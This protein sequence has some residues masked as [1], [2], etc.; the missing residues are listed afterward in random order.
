MSEPR[1]DLC[2]RCAPL[3]TSKTGCNACSS[4]RRRNFLIANQR[5]VQCAQPLEEKSNY[6]CSKCRAKAANTKRDTIRRR[7]KDGFCGEP[8]CPNKSETFRCADCAKKGAK[9]NAA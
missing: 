9:R 7:R 3:K 2:R 1:S 4:K 5:C 6:R 8:G